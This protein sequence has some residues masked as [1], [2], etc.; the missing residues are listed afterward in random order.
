MGSF[1]NECT[2][3]K[4]FRRTGQQVLMMGWIQASLFILPSVEISE[5]IRKYLDFYNIDGDVELLR[6]EYYRMLKEI[7]DIDSAT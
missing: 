3:P 4:F 5:A 2:L 1:M 7:R 6:R